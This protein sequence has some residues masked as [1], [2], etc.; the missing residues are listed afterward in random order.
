MPDTMSHFFSILFADR[1]ICTEETCDP[2]TFTDLNLDQIVRAVTAGREEYDLDPLFYVPLHDLDAVRYRQD[3]FRD[4]NNDAAQEPVRRFAEMMREMRT[5]LAQAAKMHH[6]YQ[7]NRWFVDAVD[8][9]Q[10]AVRDLC[11]GLHLADLVSRGFQDFREYLSDYVRSEGF[12]NIADDTSVILD[13][14]AQVRYRVHIRKN[15]VHV[16][17]YAG[18]VDYSSTVE[19]TLSKFQQ[20]SVNDYRVAFHET[21]EMDQVETEVLNGVRW[22]HPDTFQRLNEYRTWHSDY[23]DATI[24]KFDREIQFYLAFLDYARK[25]TTVGLPFALPQVSASPTHTYANDAY[26]LALATTLLHDERPMV[27]NDFRLDKTERMIVVTGPNQG[28][29][30]TFARMVGQ[31][32]YLASLGLPVPAIQAHLS[33]PDR[34]LTHFERGET[35]STLRG[36]LDDELIRVHDMLSQATSDT[37]LIMNESFSSTTAHDALLLGTEVLMRVIRQGALVV[38]VTF[39]DELASLAQSTVSMMSTVVRGDPPQRTYKVVRQPADG[40]A[41]AAAVAA[42][43]GLTYDSLRRRV[44]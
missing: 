36:K 35:L 25:F 18:E 17:R 30:T 15:R 44:Q 13:E 12:Q 9:Y 37:V 3:V 11:S 32:Y 38:Y 4:L 21:P 39:V 20:G 29:K 2:G 41:C 16:S 10:G 8:A 33:L 34:V 5:H 31:L 19:Q 7:E 40:L 14:L 27:R 1:E 22:L 28:G 42:K 26:D 6:K 24:Q 23:L 43:Y